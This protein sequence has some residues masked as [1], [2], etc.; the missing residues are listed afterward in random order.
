MQTSRIADHTRLMPPR[1]KQA[2]NTTEQNETEEQ[3]ETVLQFLRSTS[4]F[5]RKPYISMAATCNNSYKCHASVTETTQ[6]H[7]SASQRG[8]LDTNFSNNCRSNWFSSETG[9]YS[10]RHKSIQ[11]S[12]NPF[13]DVVSLIFSHKHKGVLA[14]IDSSSGFSISYSE[15]HQMVKSIASG[16][17]KI[18]I[19]KGDVVLFL[20]PNTIYFPVLFLGVL[21]VGAIATA[22]NPLSSLQE[23]KKQMNECNVTLALTTPGKILEIGKMGVSVV[24]VPENVGSDLCSSEFSCFSKLLSSDPNLAPRPVL[25][26]QDIAAILYSSGTSGFSKGV[27]LTQRNFMAAVELF[28]RFEASQYEKSGSENVYLACLPMFHIYGLSLFTMGLLSLGSAIVVMRKF[29]EEEMVTSIDKYRVTHLPVVPP[30]LMAMV[31]VKNES[32]CELG[33][34]KQVSCGAAPTSRKMIQD[35][36]LTFP[37]VDFIQVREH[38]SRM[39]KP[40]CIMNPDLKILDVGRM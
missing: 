18:G 40:N 19:S 23:V 30:I 13:I 34:L 20:L 3:N 21:S 38:E 11:L 8:S 17:H 26:Q 36:L 7:N 37:H 22:M 2:R 14:L 12:S 16:L 35:F 25:N 28:V 24:G 32:G 27:V 10:S 31:R 1:V 6:I 29:N 9:I 15:L 5:L 4:F 33:S 39:H